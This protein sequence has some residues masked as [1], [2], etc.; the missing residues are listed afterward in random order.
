ME[1]SFNPANPFADLESDFGPATAPAR[2]QQ[3]ASSYLADQSERAFRTGKATN[4]QRVEVACE[5]CKGRGYVIIGYTYQRSAPCFGCNGKGT[6]LRAANYA[7]N[8]AKREERKQRL[9]LEAKQ[10]A[11]AAMAAWGDQHPAE[12]KWMLE[13]RNGFEFAQAMYDSL[14]K[15]GR[16]T[17]GQMAAVQRC[18]AREQERAAQRAAEQAAAPA[19]GL[20]VSTLSGYY[21]VPGGDTRLKLRVKHPGKG[22]RYHGWVLVDDGAAYGMQQKYGSQAPGGT[23]RGKVQEQLRAILADPYAAQVAYGKLTGV[24]GHCGRPLEDAASVAAGIGP[25]CAKKYG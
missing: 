13:N 25:I 12:W 20:D 21:A 7:V 19:G 24:C 4:A 10:A 16:L 6:I 9:E 23:Y 15:W 11:A 17:D 18:V 14:Q 1:T 8:K 5:K 3:V 2:Q 22:S